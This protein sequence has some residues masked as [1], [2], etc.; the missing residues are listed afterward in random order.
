MTQSTEGTAS[1]PAPVTAQVAEP[2]RH[3]WE[4]LRRRLV[5][6]S[7][8]PVCDRCRTNGIVCPGYGE[9]QPLRWVKPGRVTAR[10]RRQPK[11]GSAQNTR[12]ARKTRARTDSKAGADAHAAGRSSAASSDYPDGSELQSECGPLS[13]LRLVQPKAL[14]AFVRY[15]IECENFAGLE[16]SYIYNVELYE[17]TTP[18]KLLVGDSRVRLPVKAV[19][20]VLPA[21]IKGLFIL[22][23]LGHQLHQLPPDAGERVRDQ[24]RSA[25]A[26]WTCRVIHTLNEDI[27][28][29]KT[30]ASDS[31]LTGVM[32]LMMAEQQMQASS[33]WR[34]HYSGLMKMLQLR[35][36]VETVWNEQPA[37][38][39]GILSCVI[40]E[41]FA[42]TTSPSHDQLVCITHPKNLEFLR[43]IW[44][45]TSPLYIG[46]ICP[47]A[48][49]SDVILI[50]HLRALASRS[51]AGSH[52]SSSSSQSPGSSFSSPL[53]PASFSCPYPSEGDMPIYTDAG[54]LLD[55]IMQFSPQS[56]AEAKGTD[57]TRDK[58]LLVGRIHQSATVLYCILALQSVF[59]LPESPELERALTTHYDRLLLDLKEGFRYENFQNCFLWPLTMAGGCACRGTAFERAFIA[60][61]LDGAAKFMG[62]S[63][64]A[65]AR[66]VL[67]AFW[68]S[69]KKRWDECFDQPYL[70]VL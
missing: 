46:S 20:K 34:L 19:A 23:A 3:C 30:R 45:G 68:G 61:L 63:M 9:Q 16:A 21:P 57:E 8:R 33:R 40:G 15:D 67:M 49:F 18:L 62:S 12:A 70:F 11:A 48:L 37:M 4:C 28:Q 14:N 54:T 2:R 64:P 65:L 38:Q 10:N 17:R 39:S 25:I 35:G 36:G 7:V 1:T 60:E 31:T 69:G 42:N 5:C 22:F 43:S 29:E 58:W 56:Y 55:H 50:N 27:T 32:M 47:P 52:T 53:P 44:D 26:F 51:V 59:L 13:L 41:V 24:A 66:K 6:D